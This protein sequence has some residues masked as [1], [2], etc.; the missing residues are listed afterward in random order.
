M[1]LLEDIIGA[2][3]CDNNNIPIT[4]QEA[5]QGV[6]IRAGGVKEESV[7]MTLL[8]CPG[9]R[10]MRA[11]LCNSCEPSNIPYPHWLHAQPH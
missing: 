9:T 4:A 11:Q 6:D 8:N 3:K 1:S 5:P 10:Y 7:E 2:L